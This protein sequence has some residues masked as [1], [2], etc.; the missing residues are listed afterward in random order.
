MVQLR[1]VAATLLA[2]T[3]FSSSRA[4]NE[5]I[6]KN[7]MYTPV[8]RADD[9]LERMTW[10]EKIGQLGG[11]RRLFERRD[12]K[13]VFNQ[14]KLDGILKDQNGNLGFGDNANYAWEVLPLTNKVREAQIS[15]TRLG[16]PFI[17]VT[18]TA[19]S[20]FV[21]GGTLF[22]GT[23]S[24]G[25][26]WNIPLYHEVVAAIRDEALA[27]GVKWV[28]SPEVDLARDPRN[29][30]NGEMYGE[31]PYHVGEF[32]SEYIRTNQEK[33]DKGYVK[34]ATTIKHFLYGQ[35]SGGI[36][37]ASIEAGINHIFNTLAA[38]YLKAFKEADP[39]S[40][41]TSYA[42]VDQVPLS[43]NEFLVRDV[44]RG[45]MGFKGLI[46][47]DAFAIPHLYTQSKVADSYADAG[48]KALRAGLEHE[49]NPSTAAEG[50]P[51]VFPLLINSV[52]DTEIAQM[53][54]D[55]VRSILLIK[56][57]TGTFDLPLPSVSALNQTLRSQRH[58]EISRNAS[59]EAMVLMKNDGILPLSQSATPKIAVLG[60]YADVVNSG[61]YSAN[62]ASL[63]TYGKSIARSL[64]AKL[65][66]DNVQFVPGV[67]AFSFSDNA[68][69]IPAAVSAAKAA[70]L[71]VVVL[72]SGWGS[73]DQTLE[74]RYKTDGEG[75]SHA[76]IGFPGSQQALLDAVLDAGVP[77]VLVL[78]G[79]QQFLLNNSTMRS[80]AIL[81]SLFQGEFAGDAVADI[82]FGEV[83]PSGKLT[84][85]FPQAQ[86]AFP[87]N[88]DYFSSDAQGG[89]PG[90]HLADWSWPLLTRY[91]PMRFGFGL[92]YTTFAFSSQTL[93]VS[94]NAKVSK[95]A[96][97]N[98]TVS[99]TV[100]LKNT[101]D[102]AGKEVVQL[103][104]RPAFSQ[105]VEFPVMKLIR[106]IKV[107]LAAGESRDVTL[108]VPIS[109]L[110]Y[111]VNAKWRVDAGLYQFWVGSSSRTEDLVQRNVTL[112]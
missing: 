110:G 70:G 47:S 24:M 89:F 23:C 9:L 54:D 76:D 105:V 62:N 30:R 102:R 97:D 27:L 51:A 36:N 93:K 26:T 66:S 17:T 4:G 98:S 48:L 111:Y 71:A 112:I 56:F 5:V 21:S 99:M 95:C 10:T 78:S 61:S 15:N 94:D 33:D 90:S 41:M 28:L 77:T 107:E 40:L 103:Y 91:A 50:N 20:I 18:D 73:Y 52:N 87:I 43:A 3:A 32:A 100:T 67:D 63:H 12:N 55:A 8:Q 75:F 1:L 45:M 19:S 104:Y 16:I 44:L 74:S 81:N 68:S 64:Q 42:T 34:V 14:T 6:Y 2:G 46:M 108:T 37:T 92:S 83:N 53:I 65:G 58:L 59:N 69:G 85:T 106:F 82:L 29:G 13:L 11:A 109:E 84:M 35:S 25:A 80:Q 101:G 60:P 86:G 72:G 88:Y 96:S 22:P 39:L 57:K 31:D 38:P 79:S 7:P 49:L